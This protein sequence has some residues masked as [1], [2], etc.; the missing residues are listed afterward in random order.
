MAERER[1]FSERFRIAGRI[2]AKADAEKDRLQGLRGPT[3]EAIK[4]Q[5]SKLPGNE[6]L[7]NSKLESMAKGSQEYR[8][9]IEGEAAAV[10]NA[11]LAWVERKAIEMEHAERADANSNQRHEARLNRG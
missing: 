11:N 1:S 4:I 5:L 10:E 2:W 7:S 8:L 3:L 9:H 6:G